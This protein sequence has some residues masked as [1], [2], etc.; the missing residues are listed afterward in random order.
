MQREGEVN[1]PIAG[2]QIG[3]VIDLPAEPDIG[4]V[5]QCSGAAEG[6][7]IHRRK[8]GWSIRGRGNPISWQ[9]AYMAW[10]PGSPTGGPFKVMG[11][12]V[13]N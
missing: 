1:A 6:M 9:A 3:D 8:S 10:G 13:E 11:L 12:S 5:L 7:R 2:Y 4:T